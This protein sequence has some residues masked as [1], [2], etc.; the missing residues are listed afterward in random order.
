L[1]DVHLIDFL[2]DLRNFVLKL[3]VRVGLPKVREIAYPPNVIAAAI[4]F[5]IFPV[6]LLSSDSTTHYCV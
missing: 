6:E 1:F 5:D 4:L 3:P 2:Q